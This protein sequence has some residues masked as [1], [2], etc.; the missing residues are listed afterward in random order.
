MERNPKDKYHQIAIIFSERFGRPI[1]KMT[2]YRIKKA[3]PELKQL[4]TV[5]DNRVDIISQ[6]KVEFEEH[7]AKKYHGLLQTLSTVQMS[8]TRKK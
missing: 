2:I 4:L 7:E 6:H 5:A 3:T 8:K 1:N